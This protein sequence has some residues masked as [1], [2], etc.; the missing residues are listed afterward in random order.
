MNSKNFKP[1][2]HPLLLQHMTEHCINT[3]EALPIVLREYRCPIAWEDK[4]QQ[5]LD[6]LKESI[7]IKPSPAP[8]ASTMFP[9]P[10][11]NGDIRLVVDY[12]L[13]NSVTEPDL[14]VV[15]RIEVLLETI[16][17][18]K[19]ISTLDLKKGFYQVDVKKEHQDKTTFISQWGKFKFLVVLFGLSNAPSSFQ[20][21][22]DNVLGD[23][24]SFALCY[25][26]DISVISIT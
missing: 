17:S 16:R 10:K 1:L 22:M 4:F 11:N 24:R 6:Y 21:L 13:L 26:N 25:I 3:G 5:E 2:Y 14:Y 19:V 23:I 20:R 18:A 8:W 7:F 9:I 15:P 12:R